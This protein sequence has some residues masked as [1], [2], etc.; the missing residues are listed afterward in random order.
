M[1]QK[2]DR[3]F[4]D[5]YVFLFDGILLLC[6][7]SERRG[8]SG[9]VSEYKLKRKIPLY[10]FDVIDVTSKESH[11]NEELLP[12]MIEFEDSMRGDVMPGNELPA[13][14]SFWPRRPRRRRRT[15]WL[16]SLRFNVGRKCS[17]FPIWM[18]L[19]LF[20]GSDGTYFF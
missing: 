9:P 8:L 13:N 3:R 17:C 12:F 11:E 5:R 6:K 7:H 4:T 16:P 1:F 19:R 2:S 14:V 15:G 18:R 10:R 20:T